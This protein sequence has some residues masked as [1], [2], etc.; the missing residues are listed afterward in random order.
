M[1]VL[2]ELWKDRKK[3]IESVGGRVGRILYA[4]IKLSKKNFQKEN[5]KPGTVAHNYKCNDWETVE[6]LVHGHLSH[7]LNMLQKTLHQT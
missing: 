2:K 1:N 4:C 6:M 5:L 7:F 3:I